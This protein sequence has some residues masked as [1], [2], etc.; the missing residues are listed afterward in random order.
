MGDGA[1]N[2]YSLQLTQGNTSARLAAKLA[3]ENCPERELA[4]E[5]CYCHSEL[6]INWGNETKGI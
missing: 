6:T 1:P 2:F 4:Q 5:G 3:A